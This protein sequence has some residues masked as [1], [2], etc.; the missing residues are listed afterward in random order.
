MPSGIPTVHVPA[1]AYHGSATT[2]AAMHCETLMAEGEWVR[3]VTPHAGTYAKRLRALGL[4]SR[5]HLGAVYARV[6]RP[7][8]WNL[9]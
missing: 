9:E 3:Y 6:H 8:V 1:G 7:D 5:A 4:Q 2:V